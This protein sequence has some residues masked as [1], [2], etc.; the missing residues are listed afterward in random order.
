MLT[1]PTD[2][3]WRA[4]RKA[5]APAFSAKSMR[6]ARPLASVCMQRRALPQV[7]VDVMLRK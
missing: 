1:G 5:V 6:C 3:Y 2:D 7:L 4:V